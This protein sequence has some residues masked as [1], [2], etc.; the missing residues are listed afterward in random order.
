[1]W[2]LPGLTTMYEVYSNWQIAREHFNHDWLKNQ[3]LPAL[4]S[5]RNILKGQVQREHSDRDFWEI[6]LPQWEEHRAE[7]DNLIREFEECMSPRVLLDDPPL[8]GLDKE[9]KEWVGDVVH[10]LWSARLSLSDLKE[11]TTYCLATADEAY[12]KLKAD[13][14]ANL[15]AGINNMQIQLFDDFRN[16]CHALARAFERFPSSIRIV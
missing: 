2:I 13:I 15:D 14:D 5:F 9:N 12:I 1:M 4:E 11:S 3:Y 6:D 8:C 10:A 7:A 16:A